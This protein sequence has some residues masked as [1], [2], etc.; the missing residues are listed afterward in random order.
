MYII[1]ENDTYD[2]D[3]LHLRLSRLCCSCGF[4]NTDNMKLNATHVWSD[5]VHSLRYANI[6]FR[7]SSSLLWTLA[8]P[9]LPFPTSA[10]FLRISSADLI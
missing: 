2:L 6:D 1:L 4:I 8:N 9:R 7:I 3:Y 5:L 10:F